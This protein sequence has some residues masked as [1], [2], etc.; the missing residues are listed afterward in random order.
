MLTTFFLKHTPASTGYRSVI[1]FMHNNMNIVIYIFIKVSR[2]L[3]V[4]GGAFFIFI[5]L[6]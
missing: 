4:E 1:E 6:S 3:G 2:I 5:V